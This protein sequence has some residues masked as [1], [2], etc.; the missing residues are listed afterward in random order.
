MY[1]LICYLTYLTISIVLTLWVGR[2]LH[3][4]G[5]VFLMDAAFGNAELADSVNHLLLVGFYLINIGYIAIVLKT[6]EIV[7][8]A[9]EAIEV[10]SGKIGLVLLVLGVMHF[11]NILVL[12]RMRSRARRRI[13]H[14]ESILA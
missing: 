7:T 3:R 4:N 1:I 14:G 5:R 2:T 12:S 13:R 6:Y 8:T 10:V 11:F 9:R